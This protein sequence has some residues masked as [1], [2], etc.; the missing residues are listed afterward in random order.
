MLLGAV[1]AHIYTAVVLT[2]RSKAARPVNYNTHKWLGGSYAVRTMRWG[3]VILLLFIVYHLLH[4]TVGMN[5][6]PVF[7]QVTHCEDDYSKCYVFQNVVSA[8]KI[9]YISLFY[10]VAQCALGLHLTHGFWSLFRTL[11]F[12]NPRW[13]EK[14]KTA[15]IALGVLITTGNCS[16]P[17]AVLFGF[18]QGG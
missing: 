4:L 15:A 17:I 16:I 8:F 12:N 9:W 14:L 2:L 3:G 1:F 13:S 5:A 6:E 11:G 18:G 7:S 10:I